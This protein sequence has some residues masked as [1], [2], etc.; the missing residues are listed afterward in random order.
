MT[1]TERIFDQSIRVAKA[2]AKW[3]KA[4]QAGH[5]KLAHVWEIQYEVECETLDNLLIEEMERDFEKAMSHRS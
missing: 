2:E 1:L 3:E 4:R 5:T